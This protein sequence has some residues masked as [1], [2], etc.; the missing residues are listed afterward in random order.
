M[1]KI[2]KIAIITVL[3]ASIFVT[4]KL[5]QNRSS[6]ETSP[7][8]SNTP[9]ARIIQTLP[10]TN[11]PQAPKSMP[12]LVDLGAGQ[13]IPCKMMA[14]ILEELK[15]EY[16][17]KLEVLLLDVHEEPDFITQYSVSIIP[18]QIFY[19]AFGKEIFRHEGFISKEDILARFKK[20]G[21][22]LEKPK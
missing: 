13:C 10:Q 2:Q 12:R 8:D 11:E 5:K 3:V 19:D 17:G 18:T 20:L 4:I 16:E 21:I 15:A 1:S 14:P 7:V 9:N 6:P 22:E